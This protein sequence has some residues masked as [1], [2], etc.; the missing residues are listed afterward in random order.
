[1]Y[2]SSHR[3]EP[4]PPGLDFILKKQEDFDTE[5]C[6]WSSLWVTSQL[7]TDILL[8]AADDDEFNACY[9]FIDKNQVQRSWCDKLGWVYFGQFG[10]ENKVSL[11]RSTSDP[12]KVV[13]YVK[14]AAE[15][16]KPKV[17]VVVGICSSMKPVQAKLGD[18]II[19]RKLATYDLRKVSQ[20]GTEY[21]GPRDT[22]SRNMGEL[23]KSASDGW[24]APLKSGND[25][26]FE[27]HRDA[28][29]LSGAEVCDNYERRQKLALDF[30]G[31]LGLEREGAGKFIKPYIFKFHFLTTIEPTGS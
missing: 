15:I 29:M 24:Q 13:I 16:L 1:M 18:V 4:P 14:N 5:P 31:A 6:K 10:D 12:M 27:I 25:S 8:I 22:I 17:A 26:T 2:E 11:I 21:H 23:I 28:V 19:A 7:P 20:S 9:S 30:P 3:V